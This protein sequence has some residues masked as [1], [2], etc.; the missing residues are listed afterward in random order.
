M[1]ST[2]DSRRASSKKKKPFWVPLTFALGF[3]L[4]LLVIANVLFA[5]IARLD[6]GDSL[7]AVRA[8]TVPS[9][10]ALLNAAVEVVQALPCTPL[11]V[12]LSSLRHS[13]WEARVSVTDSHRYFVAA[14]D[15]YTERL[16][17][18]WMVEGGSVRQVYGPHCPG[19][20]LG[21][22]QAE[23]EATAIFAPQRVL[24]VGR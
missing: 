1:P 22:S 19:V 14:I 21:S 23:S 6:L 7:S 5:V 12:P 13:S 11:A 10:Q 20:P 9:E 15:Q 2:D 18:I 3:P 8:P 24:D 17:A 16:E 4:V